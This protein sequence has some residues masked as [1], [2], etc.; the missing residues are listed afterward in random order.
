MARARGSWL[1]VA[2]CWLLVVV[3]DGGWGWGLGLLGGVVAVAVL[4]VWPVG[5][6]VDDTT[7]SE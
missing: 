4:L 2:G 6:M 5:M 7:E 1:L 3:V